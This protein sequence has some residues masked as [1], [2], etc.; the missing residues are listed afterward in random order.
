M[1]EQIRK[2]VAEQ[3]NG[4]FKSKD[5]HVRMT[6]KRNGDMACVYDAMPGYAVPSSR[7]RFVLV[8][9]GRVTKKTRMALLKSHGWLFE[10]YLLKE[11]GLK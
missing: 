2:T 4:Q 6:L 5:E 9:K 8:P 1:I 3:F 11:L 10:T 7:D